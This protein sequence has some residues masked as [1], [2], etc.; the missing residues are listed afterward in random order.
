MTSYARSSGEM[1]RRALSL[2]LNNRGLLL[3]E[4]RDKLFPD[5]LKVT[6][7]ERDSNSV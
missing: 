7:D 6:Y 3:P 2:Y 4:L 5:A 1:H